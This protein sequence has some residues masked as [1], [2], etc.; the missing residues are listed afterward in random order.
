[1]E[2]LAA[3]GFKV[4]HP[5]EPRLFKNDG[6]DPLFL[7]AWVDD[8]FCS[9]PRATQGRRQL[10]VF[11]QGMERSFPHGVKGSPEGTTVF[12][13]LGLEV[14]R[15][16]PKVIRVHQKPYLENLL[17]KS[18]F[19]EG[20]GK[21][22]D[23]PMT[24]G[25]HLSKRDCKERRKGDKE[26]AWYRSVLM[27]LNHAANWTR[28]DLTYLVS[29]AAKFMQTPG[30]AHV[31]LLKKALRYL[32]GKLDL[33]LVYDFRAT[34]ERTGLYGFF[35]ASHADDVDTR[36]S[37]IA[38]VF[39][40]SGCALSWKTKLHSYVT[41]STNHSELVAS[42]MAAREA[43][44]LCG[45]FEALGSVGKASL[46]TKTIDLFSDSKGVV[47]VAANSVL[48]AATKHLDIADF[49]VRE[50]VERGIVTVSY[51]KTEFMVA[52]VLTKPLARIKFFNFIGIIMGLIK[53][54]SGQ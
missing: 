5:S 21:P 17:R 33:G 32:R 46:M 1:M 12:H 28:P 48:S 27:S 53:H 16:G 51:V 14:E 43:K 25:V 52:D 36:R 11:I 2:K 4:L 34:P 3:L 35:D 44:Y 15:I 9:S 13:C 49:Y 41:T 39:F 24:P 54:G 31:A 29:K 6:K 10:S 18:G 50:L 47:A 26:H 30:D 45:L 40:F 23:V 20:P 8:V 7:F 19:S 38:Y 22:H 42:A 37:T